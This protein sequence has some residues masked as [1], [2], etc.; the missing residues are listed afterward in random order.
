MDQMNPDSSVDAV[1]ATCVIPTDPHENKERRGHLTDAEKYNLTDVLFRTKQALLGA[2]CP[3]ITDRELRRFLIDIF[4]TWDS[5]RQLSDS[6]TTTSS[7][8]DKAVAVGRLNKDYPTVSEIKA[9]AKR[10][11]LSAKVSKSRAYKENRDEW[12]IQTANIHRRA[13]A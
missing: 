12:N 1:R 11:N 13:G 6:N 4:H 2:D 9:E 7:M 3:D 5:T 8:K 10:R